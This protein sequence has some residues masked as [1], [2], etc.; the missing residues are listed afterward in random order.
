MSADSTLTPERLAEE[1]TPERLA[2]LE[3]KAEW[4][5]GSLAYI[6][7]EGVPLLCASLRSAGRSVFGSWDLPEIKPESFESMWDARKVI[8]G[9]LRVLDTWMEEHRDATRRLERAREIVAPWEA[10]ASKKRG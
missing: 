7:F 5:E 4:R 2:E 9:A 3:R 10:K 6:G 8:E 1:M